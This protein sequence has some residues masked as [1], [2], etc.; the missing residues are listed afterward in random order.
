[1]I[2]ARTFLLCLIASTATL[3]LLA[4]ETPANETESTLSMLNV[5]AL[6][7]H[8]ISSFDLNYEWDEFRDLSAAE[9]VTS[10]RRVRLT[11]DEQKNSWRCLIKGERQ[12]KTDNEDLKTESELLG[13]VWKNEIGYFATRIGSFSKTNWSSQRLLASTELPDFRLLGL[14]PFPTKYTASEEDPV[15]LFLGAVQSL[16]E[17]ASL[18]ELP[19]GDLKVVQTSPVRDGGAGNTTWI[20]DANSHM[21]VNYE[22][23]L[24][25]PNDRYGFLLERQ[26]LEWTEHAGLYLP[27]ALNGCRFRTR[28]TIDHN[29]RFLWRSVNKPI[30]DSQFN[31]ICLEQ[32][33]VF[34]RELG[35]E[36]DN[37]PTDN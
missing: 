21:P 19:N 9:F 8:A 26:S 32:I 5:V 20:L 15:E 11:F 16:A 18:S 35:W 27:K 4:D 22:V 24:K 33:E 37:S 30:P 13:F 1:M 31:T 23:H 12:S 29:V 14:V 28:G 36:Q 25:L 7:A 17:A 3:Q 10:K 34:D 6:N 2:Y